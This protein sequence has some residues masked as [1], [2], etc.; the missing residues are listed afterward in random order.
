MNPGDD[1]DDLNNIEYGSLVV[2]QHRVELCSLLSIAHGLPSRSLLLEFRLRVEM[3]A[4][5]DGEPIVAAPQNVE[6]PTVEE[7]GANKA[8]ITEEKQDIND[9]S[10]EKEKKKEKKSRR[11]SRSRSRSRSR[12]SSRSRSR[13]GSRSRSRSRG[14]AVFGIFLGSPK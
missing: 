4:A 9:D 11:D 2:V 13:S 14:V 6:L 5:I 8:E 1:A 12:S 7:N 10:D 3:S